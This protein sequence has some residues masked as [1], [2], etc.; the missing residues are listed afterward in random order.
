[1]VQ[2]VSLN[3]F[4]F[5]KCVAVSGEIVN[6]R[7]NCQFPVDTKWLRI[8]WLHSAAVFERDLAVASN[9]SRLQVCEVHPWV[10]RN[11]VS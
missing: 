1:M 8:H 2:D 7:K 4:K 10:K 9:Y 11:P 6:L 5:S 3:N